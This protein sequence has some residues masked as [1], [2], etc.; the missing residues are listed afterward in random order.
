MVD[1]VSCG[2]ND[3]DMSLDT[4]TMLMVEVLFHKCLARSE[5]G[6]CPEPRSKDNGDDNVGSKRLW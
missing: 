5:T 1:V 6:I 4:G 2:G 3:C